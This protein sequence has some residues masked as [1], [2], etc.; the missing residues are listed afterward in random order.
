MESDAVG[1]RRLGR[2][3]AGVALVHIGQFDRP[4]GGFLNRGGKLADLGAVLGIAGRDVGGEQ[5]AT[6]SFDPFW[7]FAPS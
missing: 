7:R 5:M 3:G 6:C 4:A 2:S 1:L